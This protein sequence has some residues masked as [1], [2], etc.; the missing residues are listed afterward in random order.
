MEAST[1]GIIAIAAAG[2]AVAAL[3][4]AVRLLLVLRG[5]RAAQRTVLGTTGEKDLIAYATGL[6]EAFDSLQVYVERTAAGL[7]ERLATA[8]QRLDAGI[9]CA[10]LVRYD[11]LNEMSGRQS[12]SIALLDSRGTGV[13]LTSIHHR[14]QA[15]LYAKLVREGQGE[16]ELSPEEADAMR[17]ALEPD[18][19]P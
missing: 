6:A 3:A 4:L 12:T 8:E 19:R 9:A 13:V 7:G 18:G 10:G 15:R 5:L 1:A 17:Q 14:D 11:A 16:L 2:V